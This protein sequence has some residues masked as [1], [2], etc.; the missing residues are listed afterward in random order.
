MLTGVSAGLLTPRMLS[1][2]ARMVPI[3][4]PFDFR[5]KIITLSNGISGIDNI[6]RDLKL[7][8]MIVESL[9]AF[10][11][12]AQSHIIAFKNI[13]D[14]MYTVERNSLS[15]TGYRP[16]KVSTGIIVIVCFVLSFS[17]ALAASFVLGSFL[18]QL[19]THVSKLLNNFIKRQIK[20]SI[21]DKVE[22][23][24]GINSPQ[25]VHRISR[26]KSMYNRKYD[27]KKRLLARSSTQSNSKQDLNAQYNASDQLSFSR[28]L[29]NI[30][31][32][33]KKGLFQ[34]KELYGYELLKWRKNQLKISQK[35][36]K[37]AGRGKEQ[38]ESE[39]EDLE[40]TEGNPW[41]LV[42]TMM[43]IP[44]LFF[45]TIRSY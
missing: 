13:E 34:C 29:D 42:F 39:E 27:G 3:S 7:I 44:E 15:I 35:T 23:K 24:G 31:S 5:Q 30:H 37:G 43:D 17:L 36:Q 8:G 1:A 11:Q 2:E 21:M 38:D 25:L 9:L 45:E 20:L 26:E 33:V 10:I 6:S 18:V 19:K 4:C 14:V 41:K 12:S 16:R 32:V 40:S 28:S 22:Q